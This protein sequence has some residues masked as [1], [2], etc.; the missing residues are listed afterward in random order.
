M[1]P[2]VWAPP[3][4]IVFEPS[5][6]GVDQYPYVSPILAAAVIADAMS[7]GFPARTK[8]SSWAVKPCINLSS[9]S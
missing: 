6:T 4:I 1:S 2:V 7:D 3:T 8:N 9:S 5:G